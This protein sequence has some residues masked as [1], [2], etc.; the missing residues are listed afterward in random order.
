[1]RMPSVPTHAARDDH[2][3]SGRSQTERADWTS[4]QVVVGRRVSRQKPALVVTRQCAHQR[5]W[6]AICSCSWSCSCSCIYICICICICIAC[7]TNNSS[8]RVV[9]VVA[10]AAVVVVVVGERLV[11]K[12]RPCVGDWRFGTGREPV[13]H[14]VV[15]LNGPGVVQQ[16]CKTAMTSEE[17][18]RKSKKKKNEN[19]KQMVRGGKPTP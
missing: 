9:V 7:E 4:A 8:S 2:A 13:Q 6:I 3:V 11:E 17:K 1:M 12:Q 19:T 14:F 10:A 16:V 15:Q 5:I 18:K